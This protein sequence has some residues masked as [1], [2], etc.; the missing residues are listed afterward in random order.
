MFLL[1]NPVML[2]LFQLLTA[3]RHAAAR[4]QHVAN[5]CFQ[6]GHLRA[7][8]IQLALRQMQGIASL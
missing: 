5:F 6:A 1:F 8:L 7:R 2:L 3:L 4:I